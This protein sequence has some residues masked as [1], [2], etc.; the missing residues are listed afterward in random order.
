MTA[1][2]TL[3]AQHMLV[4]F[5]IYGLAFFLFGSA[6]LLK[7][8]RRSRLRLRS[9]LWLLAVFGLLHGLSEWSDMFLALGETYW[10]PQIFSLIRILGFYLGLASFV[11][12]LAFGVKSVV[13]GKSRHW[14]MRTLTIAALLFAA[15]VTF[16]AIRTGFSAEWLTTSGVLTRYFLAFPASLVVAIGLLRRRR[17]HEIMELNSPAVLRNISGL[18][19]VF[20][21]YAFLAG[22]IVPE[23]P[24]PP[25]SFL[26]YTSFQNIFSFP[27]Q[28][29][30]ATCA[31]F[32]AFFIN[33]ILNVFSIAAYGELDRQVRE[34]T[35]DLASVNATLLSDIAARKRI[36]I[37]LQHSRDAAIESSRVKSQF[38]ANMSH[39]IR[40][41]MNGI[42]GMTQ[43]VLDTDLDSEQREYLNLAKLSADSLL[44]LIDDILDF[45]KI[46][47]GK[48]TVE[49]IAFHLPDSL[50]DTMKALSLRAHEK[51][52]ELA[53][54]RSPDVPDALVGDPGRLRQIITNL[55]G[56]AIKFTANGEVLLSVQVETRTA[57]AIVLRFTV[58]DT[59]IG[60]P[61]AKQSAIFESFTQVDGSTT[62]T[63]GGTGLGLTIS[64]RLS[65]LMGGRIWVESEP[66]KGSRFHFTARFALP[67]S[68]EPFIVANDPGVL[69]DMPV[70]V[71]DDN[72]TNRKILLRMLTR[73]NAI[74]TAVDSGASALAALYSAA[75]SGG[76]F[77][78]FLID[79][80]MPDMDG[81]TL[82]ERI[83]QSPSWKS[84][85]ILMLTSSG[86][87]GDAKRCRE[88]GVSAYLTKPIRQAELMSAILTALGTKSVI[89]PEQTAP[90]VTRHSLR[91]HPR[92]APLRSSPLRILLVEDNAVNRL[93]ALRLLQK[94]GD[95]VAVAGNG[96]EALALVEKQSFDLVL[97]D[98][99]MPE[100]DG[101]QATAAIREKE[102]LSGNHLPVIA[103]TAHAMVGDKERCL[104]AG[105]DDYITK[106]IDP[107]ELYDVIER[108]AAP[109]TAPADF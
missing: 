78:L 86:Q 32:A 52:L 74:P 60:I 53:H 47:A 98:V 42:M 50:G 37:E 29:F 85:T 69:R 11:F 23:A 25:A 3:A 99:Q 104:A 82:I 59:G 93:L 100:M 91:E 65:S 33:G 54:D 13:L 8:D 105:M 43:L 18:A 16:Y 89:T 71:V 63:F 27:I 108:H 109:I 22:V 4:V 34:R 81:F 46:E 20:L 57:D 77:P 68:P 28:I 73:W 26:N 62:R 76:D 102:R 80:Q 35:A 84:A 95:Q 61:V 48:L 49:N 96:M 97:M 72:A 44:A 66:G 55:V 17:S 56:N 88:L 15:L 58:A 92:T 107:A 19:I 40:T 14:L 24:F 31:V 51:G 75:D 10:T 94:R 36:E 41:P 2:S 38:L 21:A 30:R 39:E 7:T 90:L 83:Q 64:A 45:S 1:L 12:L 101:F 70:L 5:F 67:S 9:F 106:P 103:M 6:I 79:A 87:L